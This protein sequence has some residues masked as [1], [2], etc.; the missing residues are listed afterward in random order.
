MT[1]QDTFV[2]ALDQFGAIGKRVELDAALLDAAAD[3]RARIEEFEVLIPLVGSFNAGK[4]SLVNAWLQ[5]PNE[6]RLP[7]DIVPQTALATEIRAAASAAEERIEIY[8]EGDNLLRKVDLVQFEAIEKEALKNDQSQ[9]HYAKARLHSEHLRQG[10]RKVLVDMPGLDS[11]VYTHNAAIQRYLPLGSYFVMV[12]DAEQG[13]LHAS[14]IRQLRE[15]L[16]QD[17]ESAV[18]VNKID[19][20]ATGDTTAIVEHI[21]GQVREAFGKPV[22]VHT[23]S[24]H[25]DDVQAFADV[26][27]GVDFDRALT[28]FWSARTLALFNEA[29]RSL[30]TR[31]SALNVSTAE[32]DRLIAE[33]QQ[34]KEALE[35]KLR[36]D[37][38]EIG[39]RYSDRAVDRIVRDVRDA[40]REEASQLAEVCQH[41]GEA[42]FQ[43]EINDIARQTLNRTVDAQQSDT[44]QE[45]IRNYQVDIDGLNTSFAQF[46][47]NHDKDNEEW[48]ASRAVPLVDVALDAGRKSWDAARS[49]RTTIDTSRGLLSGTALA[50]VLAATTSIVAPWLEA[51]I[52]ALPLILKFF[53]GTNAEQRQEEQAQQ[54]RRE[55]EMRIRTD[56]ASKVASELRPRVADNYADVARGMIEQL[57]QRV[58]ALVA[59]VEVDINKS[60]EEVEA[61]QHTAEQRRA[62]LRAAIEDLTKAKQP[63]EAPA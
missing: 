40:I 29:E 4:T 8:G 10:D 36:K 3:D 35:D 5:R 15:F 20:K 9:A 56:T 53:G 58:S 50:G 23:V 1:S 49:V 21:Q 43:R 47:H 60:R 25:S 55:L 7:T 33:L 18:L 31:Y 37:E 54:Q 45:I 39:Q 63:L 48:S 52:I 38:R 42:A 57:R 13:T 22:P 12:V 19:K 46:V 51:I 17:V 44:L 26:L 41:G 24:A 16:D 62:E 28:T 14:G 32:S 30:H 27:A 2:A 61:Q 6:R 11:G 34:K 59:A